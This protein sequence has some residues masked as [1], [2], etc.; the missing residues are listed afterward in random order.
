M[1]LS[2]IGLLLNVPVSSN[3]NNEG[4]L[5]FNVAVQLYSGQHKLLFVVS[6]L[7]VQAKNSTAYS[8]CPIAE[9]DLTPACA[10]DKT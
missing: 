6:K 4:S 8:V 3:S 9:V 7:V 1:I 5:R 10:P 2:S